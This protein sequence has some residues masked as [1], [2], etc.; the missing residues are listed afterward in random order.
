M[1]GLLLGQSLQQEL[2]ES[3]VTAALKHLFNE[4]PELRVRLVVQAEE[5]QE[6]VRGRIRVAGG[7]KSKFLRDDLPGGRVATV[8]FEHSRLLH[9]SRLNPS[10]TDLSAAARL[11]D[12]NQVRKVL[13]ASAAAAA[14]TSTAKNTSAA[15]HA[16]GGGAE[17]K[18]SPPSSSAATL[19]RQHALSAL[20]EVVNERDARFG[21]GGWTALHWAAAGGGSGH[22]DVVLQLL[23]F[24]GT[25]FDA[26]VDA[27]AL[28]VGDLATPLH[29][30]AQR[31][32]ASV[33][34]ALVA[35][36]F[37]CVDAVDKFG[38]TPLHKA[39]EKGHQDVVALLLKAGADPR[40]ANTNRAPGIA[41][42][43]PSGKPGGKTPQQLA[44]ENGH[45]ACRALLV[46]HE[47]PLPEA[48]SLDGL[49]TG[50]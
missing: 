39:A 29:V 26:L 2:H 10:P 7:T 19:A 44:V 24:T 33:V 15:A 35:D 45:E 38:E 4:N 13:T 8:S 49:Y 25:T 3:T 41:S 37:V 32:H 30:A 22:L 42:G 23:A 12:A 31:G 27:N 36:A 40:A 47:I 17:S 18:A 28:S 34:A 9:V 14:A 48:L 50:P 5:H 20:A 43:K 21:C 16:A 6:V 1:S 11:G 46:Q